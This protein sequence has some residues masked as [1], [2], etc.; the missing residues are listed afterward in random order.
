MTYLEPKDWYPTLPTVYLSVVVLLT[1]DRD[2]VLMVKP[3]YRPYWA[4]PG[5]IIEP[6]ESPHECGEREVVEEVGLKIQ[7]RELLV[8]DFAPAL[9]D[10]PKPM[11]NFL[12][13]G[14]TV[15]D[16]GLIR[17]ESAELDGF[18]FF[19]WEEAETKLPA[20]TAARIPAARRA[21][22]QQQTIY[23]PAPA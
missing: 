22:Q 8:V 14:G 10:R 23:L 9:G 19:T 3:N 6:G 2:R 21:R 12:F 5:G 11:V 4:I 16:P 1:D 20:N 7:A 13:D 17:V 15:T 18:G